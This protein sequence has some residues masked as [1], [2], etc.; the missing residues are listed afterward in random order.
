VFSPSLLSSINLYQNPLPLSP[1]AHINAS[2]ASVLLPLAL[3]PS[4]RS[5]ECGAAGCG[6]V[7]LGAGSGAKFSHLSALLLPLPSHVSRLSSPRPS[8]ISP[9][10]SPRPSPISP[11]SSPHPSSI[12]P[13]SPPRPLPSPLFPLP[14]PSPIHLPS[15]RAS[16][17]SHLPTFTVIF[18][19]PPPLIPPLHSS[20]HLP[21]LFQV[22]LEGPFPFTHMTPHP[23]VHLFSSSQTAPSPRLSGGGGGVRSGGLLCCQVGV[24]CCQV[25]HP[26]TLWPVFHSLSALSPPSYSLVWPVAAVLMGKECTRDYL[27]GVG[28]E[29]QRTAKL[30]VWRTSSACADS[31]LHLSPGA[32][33][34]PFTPF[35]PSTHNSSDPTQPINT[36][37]HPFPPHP[38]PTSIAFASSQQLY[39]SA[40][41]LDMPLSHSPHNPPPPH[42]PTSTHSPS[43]PIPPHPTPSHPIPLHPT[44]PRPTTAAATHAEATTLLASTVSNT[45]ED[46][47]TAR[48][49]TGAPSEL[50][51]R[52][53]LGVAEGAERQEKAEEEKRVYGVSSD[54]PQVLE[55]LSCPEF[56]FGESSEQA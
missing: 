18:D 46:K 29:Q 11:L 37:F 39:N 45:K 8:P 5:L 49:I 17:L 30:S 4:L 43:H 51:E 31:Q 7:L 20:L 44:Q 2:R 13:L 27:A 21:S 26:S 35:F 47:A 32:H 25:V 6:C 9:L 1:P 36:S 55:N 38:R 48:E 41:E 14:C 16:P 33:N 54:L 34:P 22:D 23:V 10:S 15:V 3:L 52:E 40:Y 28:G 53:K 56:I 12:S 42:T 24:V 50:E 19:S